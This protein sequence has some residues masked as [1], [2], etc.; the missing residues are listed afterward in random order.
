MKYVERNT[1]ENKKKKEFFIS[2]KNLIRFSQKR[3]A[4]KQKAKKQRSG[5]EFYRQNKPNCDYLVSE[6]V[7]KLFPEN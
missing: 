3:K 6:I 5:L 7:E 4:K 1:N 2:K